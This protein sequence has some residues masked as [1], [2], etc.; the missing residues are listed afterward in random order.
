MC[1]SCGGCKSLAGQASVFILGAK[2]KLL[3]D[4]KVAA[5]MERG[6][7]GCR[8]GVYMSG[9]PSLVSLPHKLQ[10]SDEE[11]NLYWLR[12]DLNCKGHLPH[13]GRKICKLLM[14]QKAK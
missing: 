9:V 5:L 2:R 8:R 10:P 3:K 12:A 7:Q 11:V 14:I 6:G 4:L 1:K 13:M